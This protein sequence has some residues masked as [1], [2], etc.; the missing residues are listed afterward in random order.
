MRIYGWRL[1]LHPW[2]KGYRHLSFLS[3]GCSKDPLDLLRDAGVNMESSEP[4]DM[5][6]ARFAELV[7]ELDGLI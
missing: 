2:C 6:L 1:P 4:V 5:A 3:G 7:E